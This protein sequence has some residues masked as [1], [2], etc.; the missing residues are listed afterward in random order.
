MEK[1][2][3]TLIFSFAFLILSFIYVSF[4]AICCYIKLHSY[5]HFWQRIIWA[6]RSWS[7]VDSTPTYDARRC[8]VSPSRLLLPTLLLRVGG[9]LENCSIDL[10]RAGCVFWEAGEHSKWLAGWVVWVACSGCGWGRGGGRVC[11]GNTQTQTATVAEAAATA[12]ATAN[13]DDNKKQ[14]TIAK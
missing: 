2:A 4:E 10:W 3:N 1:N 6:C 7:S 11:M 13:S 14:R 12:A 8:S 9:S 5:R